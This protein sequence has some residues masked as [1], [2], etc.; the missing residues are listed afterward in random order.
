MTDPTHSPAGYDEDREAHTRLALPLLVPAMVF[1]FAVLVIYGLS[2]IYLELD[3]YHAGDVSM[4]TPLAI[5][6][7]LAI[8]LTAAYFASQ[9]RVSRGQVGFVVVLAV[10]LLTSG[11]IWAAVHNEPTAAVEGPTPTP[12]GTVTPG[13]IGVTLAEFNV[14]LAQASAP[15]GSVTF[16]VSNIG[17]AIHNFRVIK[18]EL[19]PA[20]LP[21]NQDTFAVDETAVDVIGKLTE[22]DI[23]TTNDLTVDLEA[24]AYAL[25]CN[26]PGHYES[27]M[28]AAFTVE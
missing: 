12:G 1:L 6:V 25:I 21:V 24:G 22:M 27:G 5:G 10:A 15:A 18:T 19:D 14:T 28:H 17:G 16:S 23:G 11:S 9:P 20:A 2:R 4:A 8:L 7:A 26:V 3:T 13:G